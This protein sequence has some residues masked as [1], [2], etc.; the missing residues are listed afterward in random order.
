MRILILEDNKKTQRKL[1]YHVLLWKGYHPYPPVT[2]SNDALKLLSSAPV[3]LVLLQL[4]QNNYLTVVHIASFIHDRKLPVPFII[5]NN[6]N[7]QLSFDSLNKYRPS[8]YI[9]EPCRWPSILAAID[10]SMPNPT[11][12]KEPDAGNTL[13]VKTGR[14]LERVDLCKLILA[15]A[16]G[17][18]TELHFSFGKRLV[19]SSLQGFVEHYKDAL[20]LIRVHKTYAVNPKY[21]SFY[22]T[23]EIFLGNQK[24]PV[25]RH[26]Q[27]EIRSYL[28][29]ASL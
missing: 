25:G 16:N 3:D 14:R 11:I 29:G 17:K 15:K 20:T 21:I 19:R 10:L 28:D 23:A 1:Y 9:F 13:V 18:Y 27:K 4:S 12:L 2:Q 22:T 24:I 26:F 5:I 7:E 8:A 6:N